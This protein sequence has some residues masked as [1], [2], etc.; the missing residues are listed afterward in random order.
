MGFFIVLQ[1]NHLENTLKI[2][3]FVLQFVLHLHMNLNE[4]I[5]VRVRQGTKSRLK[6]AAKKSKM[7]L[8]NYLRSR[9][10]DQQDEHAKHL[11]I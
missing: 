2:N 3:L 10:E 8:S 4:T 1:I 7:K 5:I 11:G 9:L 6:K